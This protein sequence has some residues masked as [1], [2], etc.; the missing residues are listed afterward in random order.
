M[1]YG[2]LEPA[3]KLVNQKA[4]LVLKKLA[5]TFNLVTF[6]SFVASKGVSSAKKVQGKDV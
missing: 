5:Q 3:S 6:S 1:F 4:Q 2:Y